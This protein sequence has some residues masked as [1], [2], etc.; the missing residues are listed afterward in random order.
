MIPV[1]AI[2]GNLSELPETIFFVKLA[3]QRFKSM[4]SAP[5]LDGATIEKI[6]EFDDGLEGIT[7]YVPKYQ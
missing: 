3:H 6:E 1:D 5:Y 2:N 4:V 7:D